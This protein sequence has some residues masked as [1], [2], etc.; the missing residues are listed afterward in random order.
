M[1]EDRHLRLIL[2]IK[3]STV[4]SC[5]TSILSNPLSRSA[6]PTPTPSSSSTANS[7]S[8]A[9]SS[10]SSSSTPTPTPSSSSNSSSTANSTAGSGS[11]S[12]SNSSYTSSSTS[13]SNFTSVTSSSSTTHFDKH[14]NC[15]KSESE[16]SC[17]GNYC[18]PAQLLLEILQVVPFITGD[19][20]ILRKI[21]GCVGINSESGCPY[22]RLPK[23]KRS[24]QHKSCNGEC[25]RLSAM[26]T[27][28]E[29]QQLGKKTETATREY[30][31][32]KRLVKL[33]KKD[34]SKTQEKEHQEQII[35]EEL[36]RALGTD[37][38][39]SIHSSYKKLIEEN[40]GVKW[41]PMLNIPIFHITPCSLHI[42]LCITRRLWKI[43]K[44]TCYELGLSK[45]FKSILET[46]KLHY[47]TSW[48]K[49]QDL[50]VTDKKVL[51]LIG[52]DCDILIPEMS[53]QL[54]LLSAK[55]SN[56]ELLKDCISLWAIFSDL[57]PHWAKLHNKRRGGKMSK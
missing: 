41:R 3:E 53:H 48:L 50:D 26:F 47:V 52:L 44:E 15:S 55:V 9:N 49:R 31:R 19:D 46:M 7:T 12:N 38:V 27:Q 4:V 22:C 20:P 40:Y 36:K 11:N 18:N 35:V 24:C 1:K 10:S 32:W 57:K 6:T 56:P 54:S 29:L 5:S 13:S 37:N 51:V 2:N 16:H 25:A 39:T 28:E 45:Y 42:K 30:L 33:T 23:K 34:V 8:I 43:S 17:V 14:C 21:L